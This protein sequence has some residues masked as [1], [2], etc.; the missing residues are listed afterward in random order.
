ME[1]LASVVGLSASGKSTAIRNTSGLLAEESLEVASFHDRTTGVVSQEINSFI[2]ERRVTPWA[3]F[4][5]FLAARRQIIDRY[6][7]PGMQKNDVVLTDRYYPCTVAYQAYGE[8]LDKAIAE[9]A[10]ISAVHGA[11]PTRVFFLDISAEE[12]H[13]RMR[14]RDEVPQIFETETLQ[15]HQRVRQGYIDQAEENE[16]FTTIDGTLPPEVVAS[17]MAGIILAD[18]GMG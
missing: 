5:M 13:A 11:L 16:H 6:I 10:A 17:T 14:D 4:Y 15:F 2:H 3:R 12:S 7:I 18:L 9:P 8:G 1:Y